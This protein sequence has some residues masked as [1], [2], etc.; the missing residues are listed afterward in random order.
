MAPFYFDYF[1][2]VFLSESYPYTSFLYSS[3]LALVFPCPLYNAICFGVPDVL[4][5][6]F[7]RVILDPLMA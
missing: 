7:V 3:S 1:L 5:V 2:N 4:T 6:Q